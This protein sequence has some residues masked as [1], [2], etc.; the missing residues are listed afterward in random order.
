VSKR[1]NHRGRTKLILLIT[2][3]VLTVVG[4]VGL[5][6]DR[7]DVSATAAAPETSTTTASTTVAPS[8]SLTTTS[9]VPPTETPQ[10][11]LTLLATAYRK[12]DVD[13]LVSRLNPAVIDRFGVDACRA[14]L[15]FPPDP[16][17][18]FTVKNVSAP[19]PFEYTTDTRSTTVPDTLFVDVDQVGGGS[20]VS[21][22]VHLTPVDGKLTWFRN[23]GS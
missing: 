16:T 1:P 7:T 15:T 3:A 9:T 22:T 6:V 23:C 4:V 5:L 11:F 17:A 13:F 8:V 19:M 21:V 20:E 14:N 2:G 10:E 18:A 12:D